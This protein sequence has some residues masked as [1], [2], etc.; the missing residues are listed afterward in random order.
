MTEF[1]VA[2]EHRR[3]LI[4]EDNRDGAE[5]LRLLLELLGHDV[6]VAYTGRAG[7]AI[8]REW[9]P[10]VVVCDIGLPE[11][12]GYGVARELRHTSATASTHLIALT[13]YGQEEDRRRSLEAGFDV[14]LTKPA[15]PELLQK[16]IVCRPAAGRDSH[17]G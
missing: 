11:L 2:C 1:A 17:A 14:H 13:G 12:D 16:L 15:E 4:V 3:V 5:S 7:L 10:D 9:V 6:R 8:A